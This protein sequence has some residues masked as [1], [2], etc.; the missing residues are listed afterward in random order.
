MEALFARWKGWE[1]SASM[2]VTSNLSLSPSARLWEKK[3]ESFARWVTVRAINP[4]TL[5]IDEGRNLWTR[6]PS[7]GSVDR[8]QFS[9]LPV[10]HIRKKINSSLLGIEKNRT[11]YALDR[12]VKG[13]FISC[14]FTPRFSLSLSLFVIKAWWN[15]REREI[16]GT[17]FLMSPHTV[18]GGSIFGSLEYLHPLSLSLPAHTNPRPTR[19]SRFC[20]KKGGHVFV[21]DRY[22]KMCRVNGSGF[23]FEENPVEVYPLGWLQLSAVGAACSSAA[24]ALCRA[25][26]SPCIYSSPRFFLPPLDNPT[27]L[28]LFSSALFP[29]FLFYQ[30]FV[31]R[32]ATKRK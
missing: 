25:N 31:I 26:F 22:N 8:Y 13:S 21:E 6:V 17:V 19:I 24:V 27:T 29:P 23:R 28:S 1:R 9:K 7:S 11:I 30:S 14:I 18:R 5:F 2:R 4:P 12:F 16:Y 20:R 32:L 3:A 10:F 15:E